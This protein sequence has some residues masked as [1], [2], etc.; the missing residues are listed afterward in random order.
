M[1][2]VGIIAEIIPVVNLA[3]NYRHEMFIGERRKCRRERVSNYSNS[4]SYLWLFCS[5]IITFLDN[6]P[7]VGD[8][9]NKNEGKMLTDDEV[10]RILMIKRDFSTRNK[11]SKQDYS[12]F[13]FRDVSLLLTII[14]RLIQIEDQGPKKKEGR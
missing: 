4:S 5:R 1:V 13:Y 12:D 10:T 6:L 7:I 8:K 2:N 3:I 14:E 9:I 11:W